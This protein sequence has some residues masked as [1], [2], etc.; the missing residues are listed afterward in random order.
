MPN[1]SAIREIEDIQQIDQWSH[2][3]PCLIYKHS[4]RCSISSVAMNRLEKGWDLTTEEVVPFYLD[5]IAHRAV[6]DFIA[7]HYGVQHESPQVLL[8]HQGQCVYHNSHLGISAR[9]IKKMIGEIPAA[10]S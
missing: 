9:A 4:T 2:E 3:K 6:S 7:T 8:I 10:N 1:W 5:L